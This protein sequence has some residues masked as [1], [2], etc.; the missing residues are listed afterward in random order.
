VYTFNYVFEDFLITG[1][2][3]IMP[4][5]EYRITLTAYT[6]EHNLGIVEIYDSTK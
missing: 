4:P 1:V 2:A 3:A 5:A 6:K